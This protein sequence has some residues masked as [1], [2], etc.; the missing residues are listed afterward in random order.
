MCSTGAGTAAGG[1]APAHAQ[2]PKGGMILRLTVKE[3]LKIILRGRK[4]TA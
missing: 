2:P 4:L 1:G 3:E